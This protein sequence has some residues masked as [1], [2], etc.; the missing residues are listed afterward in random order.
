LGGVA[1]I[2]TPFLGRSITS[3]FDDEDGEF[4]QTIIRTYNDEAEID[5]FMERTTHHSDTSWYLFVHR[6]KSE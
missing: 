3:Y 6:K 1:K 2:R 4:Y 5:E